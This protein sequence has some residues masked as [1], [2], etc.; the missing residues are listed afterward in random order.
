M[1]KEEYD[2]LSPLE[3]ILGR[4][5]RTLPGVL[6]ANL[7]M[8]Y[9]F[10]LL[11]GPAILAHVPHRWTFHLERWA[12]LGSLAAQVAGVLA[13]QCLLEGNAAISAEPISGLI[14]AILVPFLLLNWWTGLLSFMHHTHP[15]VRWYTDRD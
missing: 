7:R 1:S 5:S 11:P 12:I 10:L 8:A 6:I 2:A 15:K 9:A 13:C 3:R 14:T 4:I